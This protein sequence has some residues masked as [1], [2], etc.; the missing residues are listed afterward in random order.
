VLLERNSRHAEQPDQAAAVVVAVGRLE[1]LALLALILG[2]LLA[3]L[4]D[5]ILERRLTADDGKDHLADGV[6]RGSQRGLG[7]LTLQRL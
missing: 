5:E 3:V 7:D 1:H 4:R 6:V 2:A